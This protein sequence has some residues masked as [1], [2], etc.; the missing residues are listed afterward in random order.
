MIQLQI[1]IDMPPACRSC[2]LL[3]EEFAYCHGHLTQSAWELDEYIKGP[4]FSKPDWCPLV[5]I[6]CDSCFLDN[7]TPACPVTTCKNNKNYK[8]DENE[9]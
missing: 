4:I 5:E 9:T 6:T 2:L 1:D 3:D 7:I 8:K